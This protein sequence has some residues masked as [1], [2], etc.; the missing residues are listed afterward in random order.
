MVPHVRLERK[1]SKIETLTLAKNYIMALTNVVCEMRGE[2][3]PYNMSKGSE[4]GSTTQEAF[5]NAMT[6]SNN[7]NDNE[8]L[9]RVSKSCELPSQTDVHSSDRSL[10]TAPQKCSSQG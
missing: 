4:G 2:K 3:S 7:G 8:F 10:W 6:S 1:L 9:L 5:S